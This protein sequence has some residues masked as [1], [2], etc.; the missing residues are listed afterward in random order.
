MSL[1]LVLGSVLLLLFLSSVF[2]GSETGF[3]CISPLRVQVEAQEGKWQARLIRWLI[4]DDYALLITIL[5][6][7]NLMLEALTHVVG[8][9]VQ[10][11]ELVP[12]AWLEVAVTLILAPIVFFTAELVP[13]ELFRH[14]RSQP[15]A[16]DGHRRN[17]IRQA[18]THSRQTRVHRPRG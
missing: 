15:R 9:A 17:T 8:S 1:T 7:N 10:E 12:R 4:R 3:Y 2:S 14:R 16:G 6:G 5:I 13:K 18:F 11:R